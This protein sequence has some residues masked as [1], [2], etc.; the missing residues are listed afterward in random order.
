VECV[1]LNILRAAI[2]LFLRH[3]PADGV[4]HMACLTPT[5][6]T[7]QRFTDSQSPPSWL[8]SHSPLRA[9]PELAVHPHWSEPLL[10]TRRAGHIAAKRSKGVLAVTW[11]CSVLDCIPRNWYGPTLN[12]LASHSSLW[13]HLTYRDDDVLDFEVLQS[14][15]HDGVQTVVMGGISTKVN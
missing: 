2:H 7:L 6:S 5:R 15:H 1:G 12:Q 14:D 9:G 8:E 3:D 13:I 4:G 10:A 11:T